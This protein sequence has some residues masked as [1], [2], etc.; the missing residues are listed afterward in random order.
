M[1]K[2]GICP[3][4]NSNK[5]IAN[6]TTIDRGDANN[7][8]AEMS[9]ATFRNP[10]ALLFRGKQTSTVSAWVCEECGFIE[11]YADNPDKLKVNH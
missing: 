5:V 3:K 9:I 8:V 10:Q 11:L 4:C 2:T 1:R 7:Q 6:A